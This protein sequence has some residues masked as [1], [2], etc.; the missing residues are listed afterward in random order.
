MLEMHIDPALPFL[1]ISSRLRTLSHLH[2]HCLSKNWIHCTLKYYTT[3][4]I[5]AAGFNPEST[6]LSEIQ[7][8]RRVHSFILVVYSSKRYKIKKYIVYGII[9]MQ[10]NYKRKQGN[11]KHKNLGLQLLEWERNG[12]RRVLWTECLGHPKIHILKS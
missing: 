4:K 2:P 5:T 7:Q 6:I 9:Y 1:G 12:S 10:I 8:V 11:Y 3:V